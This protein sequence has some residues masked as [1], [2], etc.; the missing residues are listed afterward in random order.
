MSHIPVMLDEVVAAMAPRDNATYL[1]ATF[2]GGGYAR[3]ILE[4]A[5][6]TLW[7]IDRDPAAIARGAALAAEF[8]GR[9]H[10]IEG[11]FGSMLELLHA[12]GIAALD[13]IVLV[14]EAET[15]RWEIVL[16]AKEILS[17][18]GAKIVGGILNKRREP[19]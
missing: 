4:R 12:A 16:R 14:V 15:V 5:A 6:C 3:A 13:G 8:P 10:L 19:A 18:A 7:A 11:T 2:G 9:L 17:R 1:D